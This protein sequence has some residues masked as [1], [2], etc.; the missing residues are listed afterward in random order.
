MS[1]LVLKNFPDDLHEDLRTQAKRN[2]R[3]VTKEAL[4]LIEVGI[5]T[6]KPFDLPPPLTLEGGPLTIEE[7][8]DAI[9]WGQK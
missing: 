4:R 9:A 2:H 3:S 8:E 1:T 6:E 7:I 5:K